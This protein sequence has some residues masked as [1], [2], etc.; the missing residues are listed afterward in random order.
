[1]RKERSMIFF[2]FYE[3]HSIL[4]RVSNYYL[5][6]H[7]KEEELDGA[8]STCRREEKNVQSLG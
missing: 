5:G 2:S 3:I 7:M 4:I 6:D 8:C 1:M